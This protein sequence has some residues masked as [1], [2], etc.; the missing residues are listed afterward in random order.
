MDLNILLVEDA[1]AD[2]T[3]VKGLL[4]QAFQSHAVVTHADSLQAAIDIMLATPQ[5][6][7]LVLLDLTLPDSDGAKTLARIR[8]YVG[9]TPVIVLSAADDARHLVMLDAAATFVSKGDSDTLTS[10]IVQTLRRQNATKTGTQS[11]SAR[12]EVIATVLAEMREEA[13]EG[14]QRIDQLHQDFEEMQGTLQ[15]S[16]DA[17]SGRGGLDARV[18]ALEKQQQRMESAAQWTLR[19]LFG[20]AIASLIAWAVAAAT[21]REVS[22]P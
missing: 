22:A 15:N 7:D 3:L 11:L 6:F 1:A 20:A 14:G 17:I 21:G 10:L 8:P 9:E 5:D 16:L 13:K 12:L 19:C 4:D 2:A 18:E